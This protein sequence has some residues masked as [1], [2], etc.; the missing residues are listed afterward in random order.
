MLYIEWYMQD[1]RCYD[2]GVSAV[3]TEGELKRVWMKMTMSTV[4]E[5]TDRDLAF[6]PSSL[7]RCHR[8][9]YLALT[10]QR[11]DSGGLRLRCG[12]PY[13]DESAGPPGIASRAEESALQP[14]IRAHATACRLVRPN[15]ACRID[16][17]N[18]IVRVMTTFAIS[19]SVLVRRW[20]RP[21]TVITDD[22]I[23]LYFH[24]DV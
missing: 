10:R 2:D 19:S 15:R 8:E 12:R 1:H 7:S 18:A 24:W 6:L 5:A 11:G 16:V 22:D 20:R 14:V 4:A 23:C 17:V 21:R 9:V 3:E 13:A